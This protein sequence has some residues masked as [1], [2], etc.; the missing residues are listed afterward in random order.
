MGFIR[1]LV[2]DDGKLPQPMRKGA[3]FLAAPEV[4]NNET[5]ANL[6]LGAGLISGGLIQQ[7]LTL[8]ADRT[9]TTASAGG[10]LNRF[11]TM[12]VGDVFCFVVTN[13]QAAAFNIILAGGGSVTVIGTNNSLI[14]TPGSSRFFTLEKT[15]DT[16][17]NLT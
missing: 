10:I 16:T 14:V 3:G 8:T 1:P 12:D 17:L 5:D 9:W 11:L 7:N 4:Y 2:S 13:A 6:T 15:S